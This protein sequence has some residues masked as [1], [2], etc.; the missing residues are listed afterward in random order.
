MLMALAD[1]LAGAL[2]TIAAKG[3]LMPAVFGTVVASR[4]RLQKY[5]SPD[6]HPP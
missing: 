3:A 2:K 6:P 1:G 4:W 5:H